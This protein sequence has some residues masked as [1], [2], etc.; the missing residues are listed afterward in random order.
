MMT[1]FPGTLLILS[2]FNS[3]LIKGFVACKL[4]ILL[5]LPDSLF[6]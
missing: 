3:D 5:S 6:Y 2:I 1:Y 4:V